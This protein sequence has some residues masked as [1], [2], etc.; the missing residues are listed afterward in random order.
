MVVVVPVLPVLLAATEV[1]VLPLLLLL[2]MP[3][4]VAMMV[5]KE[6]IPSHRQKGSAKV[7][8]ED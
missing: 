3:L 1:V 4:L 2:A 7:R 8:D 6:N 5:S